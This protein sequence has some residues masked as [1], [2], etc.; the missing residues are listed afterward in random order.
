[1]DVQVQAR[2]AVYGSTLI[3]LT[4]AAQIAA[5]QLAGA[6]GRVDAWELRDVSTSDSIELRTASERVPVR[7]RLMWGATAV[8]TVTLPASTSVDG[9]VQDTPATTA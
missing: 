6:E 8:L 5:Q 2:V 7:E 4:Q 1:M 3:E 9:V